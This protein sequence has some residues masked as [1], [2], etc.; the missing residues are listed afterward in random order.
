MAPATSC[1]GEEIRTEGSSTYRCQPNRAK[2]SGHTRLIF[3]GRRTI[4]SVQTERQ[5]TR[6]K[7]WSRNVLHDR[8]TASMAAP[9]RPPAAARRPLL[10]PQ[11]AAKWRLLRG[12]YMAARS[13]AYAPTTCC[14]YRAFMRAPRGGES[15]EEENSG[16]RA[17][18]R[19]TAT[20]A[21]A[22][23]ICPILAYS[24]RQLHI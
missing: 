17:A 4:S 12:F 11:A 3:V 6:A 23:P 20:R 16:R 2:I 15:K 1:R 9:V 10:A 5:Q 7:S 22:A 18:R 21:G 8:S 19:S 24:S 14:A 13:R